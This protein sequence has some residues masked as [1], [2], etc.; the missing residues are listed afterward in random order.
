MPKGCSHFVSLSLILVDSVFK[1][2]KNYYSQVFLGDC[3]YVVKENKMS[4]F[5]ND[6]LEISSDEEA[7]DNIRLKINLSLGIFKLGVSA[8]CLFLLNF[9]K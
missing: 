7:S 1:M 6:E 4:K 8:Q 2:D 5:I 3:K 9:S